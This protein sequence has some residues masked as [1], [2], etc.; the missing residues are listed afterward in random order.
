MS[1]Q[2]IRIGYAITLANG[3]VDLTIETPTGPLAIGL[4][5]E[6]AT[7]FGSELLV[8][9]ATLAGDPTQR[10][11]KVGAGALEVSKWMAAPMMDRKYVGLLT[12]LVTG[13]TIPLAFP[14]ESAR[15]LVKGLEQSIALA[16]AAGT[17]KQ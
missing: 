17:T 11:I 14:V 13:G 3:V 2:P 5:I 8:A 1:E 7:A 10:D 6:S 16:E 4:S 15:E 12:N 9:A